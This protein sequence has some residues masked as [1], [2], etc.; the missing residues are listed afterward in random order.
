MQ[1]IL[2]L[3]KELGKRIVKYKRL[4]KKLLKIDTVVQLQN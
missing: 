4:L 1:G 3:N 2:Y